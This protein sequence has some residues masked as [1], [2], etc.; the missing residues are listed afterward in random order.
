MFTYVPYGSH[1][2][3]NISIYVPYGC[4]GSTRIH[5]YIYYMGLVVVREYIAIWDSV[6]DENILL[7][8]T[9][10]TTRVCHSC[11]EFQL[12]EH[13]HIEVFES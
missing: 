11:L 4:H 10:G 7:Y 6:Y 12:L 13:H 1:D 3:T 8:G 9:H 2:S 5:E